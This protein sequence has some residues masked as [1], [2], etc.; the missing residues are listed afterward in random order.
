[1]EIGVDGVECYFLLIRIKLLNIN[2]F[3]VT[4]GQ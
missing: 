4:Q 3:S 1:M 2:G